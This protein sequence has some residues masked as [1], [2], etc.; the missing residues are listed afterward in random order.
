MKPMSDRQKQ[1]VEEALKILVSE[2]PRRFTTQRLASRIGVT[3][4]AIFRH[5]S[6]MD[7]IVD[8]VVDRVG[9][10]LLA[11]FPSHTGDPI[12]RLATFFR[13]RIRTIV[14]HPEVSRLLLS[15]HLSHAAEGTSIRRLEAFKR[16]SRSFVADCLKEADER[17]I[18][19]PSVRPEVG[20]VIVLG[21][22]LA[23]AHAGAGSASKGGFDALAADV[24]SSIERQ[25]R[26]AEA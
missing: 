17:R 18:L 11:D 21:A 23:L 6:S 10:V 7:D 22:I 3:T 25:L 26:C 24:W 9:D 12:E 1:I 8:A 19:A 13:N 5:F 15:E 20:A 4:G 16:K 2:G 14:Q